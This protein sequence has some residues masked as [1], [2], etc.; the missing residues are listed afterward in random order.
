LASLVAIDNA[1]NDDDSH[2]TE[3]EQRQNEP[4]VLEVAGHDVGKEQRSVS[5]T[6]NRT[7][8]DLSAVCRP[9]GRSSSSLA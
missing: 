6:G 1:K 2:S 8:L 5:A 4:A 7:L 3:A 9:V